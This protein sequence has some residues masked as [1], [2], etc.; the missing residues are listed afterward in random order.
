MVGLLRLHDDVPGLLVERVE[1]LILPDGVLGALAQ[2]RGGAGVPIFAAE[3][4]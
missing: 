1:L 4:E 2:G 3:G